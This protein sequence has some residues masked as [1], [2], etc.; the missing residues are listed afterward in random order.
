MA[1]ASIGLLMPCKH[2]L[3]AFNRRCQCLVCTLQR[4]PVHAL[5]VFALG[6]LACGRSDSL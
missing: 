3:T 6:I 2:M 4:L 5:S 1:C